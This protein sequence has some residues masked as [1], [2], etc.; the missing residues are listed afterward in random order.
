MTKTNK[1]LPEWFKEKYKIEL[2]ATFEKDKYWV[3]MG[4][5]IKLFNED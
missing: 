1:D 2:S 4:D 5:A 3:E